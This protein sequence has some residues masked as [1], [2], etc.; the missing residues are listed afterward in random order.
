MCR[1]RTNAVQ[2]G[3]IRIY[4]KSDL[5]TES[6]ERPTPITSRQRSVTAVNSESKFKVLIPY[7]LLNS[8]YFKPIMFC[9]CWT[10]LS[11][12]YCKLSIADIL[13]H[14]LIAYC[15]ILTYSIINL[16]HTVYCW[17]ILSQTYSIMSIADLLYHKHCILSIAG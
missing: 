13:Y 9:L 11:Q 14:K 6:Y 16:F 12:T 2:K 8:V 4:H 1:H 15:L 7:F 3:T 5:R 10:S 17:P